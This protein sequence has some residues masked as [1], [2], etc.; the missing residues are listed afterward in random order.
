MKMATRKEGD[1]AEEWA[2]DDGSFRNVEDIEAEDELDVEY[3][4]DGIIDIHEVALKPDH[5]VRPLLVSPDK[6]IFL[7]TFSPVYRQAVEFLIAIAEPER[8]PQHIH[9]Y[10]L[11]RDSLYAAAS[12]GLRADY[13]IKILNRLSKTE[14]PS[15]VKRHI[16]RYTKRYGKVTLYVQKGKYFLESSD[17]QALHAVLND[18]VIASFRVSESAHEDDAELTV[19]E[20]KSAKKG[21]HQEKVKDEVSDE[22]LMAAMEKAEMEATLP[23]DLRNLIDQIDGVETESDDAHKISFEIRSEGVETIQKRLL[24]DLKY[25]LL[26]EYDFVNDPD[27]KSIRLDL[28]PTCRLRPYQEKSLKKMFN[29]GR[30]RSGIIVLPCGAGKTLTGV[31]AASTIKKPVIVLCTSSVAV[32]QWQREFVRWCDVDPRLVKRFTSSDKNKPPEN[33]ILCATYSMLA[34]KANR[35][36]EAKR[37]INWIKERDWGL[38][39]LDEVQTVPAKT[40]RELLTR[41]P[42]RCKLGL[43]ATLVREDGKISDLRFMVGPKLYEANWIDLQEC[44]Y[45]ARVKCLEVWCPMLPQFYSEY[46][47]AASHRLKLKLCVCNPS[48]FMAA[49]FLIRKHEARGDKIIVF[50]DDIDAL[51][52][53][54]AGLNRKKVYG[55]TPPKER[56]KILQEYK[57]RDDFRTIMFSK[58]ADN[59]FDLPEANVLIQVASQG[60]GRR[61]EAQRLGRILRAKANSHTRP[62]EP[63]AF[64]YSLVSKDTKEMA[65]ATARQRFLVDQGYSFQ[66]LTYLKGFEEE[67]EK[68][69]YVFS[70]EGAQKDMLL[71]ILSNHTSESTMQTGAPSSKKAKTSSSLLSTSIVPSS[72][73]AHTGADAMVYREQKKKSNPKRAIHPILRKYYSKARQ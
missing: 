15:Q 62:G 57:E 12:L 38:M 7:E 48:K 40:F 18:D 31:A 66:V 14:L 58:I 26:L 21:K 6:R 11:T 19:D 64:F 28:K 63:N 61:Q 52:T 33:C 73:A 8:R 1:E 55:D 2:Q 46:C 42:A 22:D 69:P 67:A 49:E 60:G 56:E 20:E 10:R 43:T 50:S 35:S 25:P 44:G 54:S 72:M 71:K 41:I 36:E 30:A 47:R 32:R 65:Y 9:E 51:K 29:Q 17:P 37:M 4:E 23:E 5:E 34:S 39:I 27:V 16:M 59:A 24:E 3:K 13:I 68:E 70:S 53:L 45:I